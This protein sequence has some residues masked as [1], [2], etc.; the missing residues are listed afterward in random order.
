[1]RCQLCNR[2]FLRAFVHDGM[3]VALH[4]WLHGFL[5]LQVFFSS[6]IWENGRWMLQIVELGS[7]S[8]RN[9]STGSDVPARWFTVLVPLPWKAML[10][11]LHF[12]SLFLGLES[13]KV[14]CVLQSGFEDCKLNAILS[15]SIPGKQIHGGGY[16]ATHVS[17]MWGEEYTIFLYAERPDTRILP[18]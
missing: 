11:N 7:N 5:S 15:L 16:A 10:Q 13:T 9:V 4:C 14:I 1:M 12:S 18:V 3:G 8:R 17:D 6:R 2:F